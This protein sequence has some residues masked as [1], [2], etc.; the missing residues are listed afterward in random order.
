MGKIDCGGGKLGLTLQAIMLIY[1]WKM[2]GC[3]QSVFFFCD[4]KTLEYFQQLD[5]PQ[6]PIY[7]LSRVHLM[8][9][10]CVERDPGLCK[11]VQ[12]ADP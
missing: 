2:T 3:E 5:T 11:E 7:F 8:F 10:R 9:F 1:D 6:L 4:G 12:V